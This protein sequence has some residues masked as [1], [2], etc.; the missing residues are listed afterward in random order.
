MPKDKFEALIGFAKRAAKIVYGYDE[1]KKSRRIRLLAV[2]DTASTNLADNMKRLAESTKT[3]LVI[4]PS[5]ENIV[6]GNCKALGITDASMAK[7]MT[8]FVSSSQQYQ[9]YRSTEVR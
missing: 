8:D 7:G 3:P 2:S 9:I 4:A 5:L 1:L 6:G